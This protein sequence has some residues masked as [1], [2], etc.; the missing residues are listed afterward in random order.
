MNWGRGR[1]VRLQERCAAV[2]G[3]RAQDHVHAPG[4][5]EQDQHE[6]D[7]GDHHQ[8]ELRDVAVG[9]AE[10]AG[11]HR[12]QHRRAHEE[13][14]DRRDR[15]AEERLQDLGHAPQHVGEPHRAGHQRRP[16]REEAAEVPGRL[17]AVPHF[18]D[19][20]WARQPQ[21]API[22]G[23]QHRDRQRDDGADPPE[24][25][26]RHEA[27]GEDGVDPERVGPG[28]AGHVAEADDPPGQLATGDHVVVCCRAASTS[29]VQPRADDAD[30]VDADHRP[31]EPVHHTRILC[32]VIPGS[33][34]GVT[35]G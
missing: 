12:V 8:D 1:R 35:P 11:E 28:R 25:E 27:A 22:A 24:A 34:F 29:E 17:P 3:D 31:V 23:P 26:Q 30:D 20:A 14:Q 18:V 5:V 15:P 33:L 2:L 6:R 9:H 32:W 21:A 7:P 10:Q 4:E 16:H 13:R 19:L